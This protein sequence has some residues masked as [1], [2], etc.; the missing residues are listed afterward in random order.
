[1]MKGAGGPP[2]P[3]ISIPLLNSGGTDDEG[4]SPSVCTKPPNKTGLTAGG[5]GGAGDVAEETSSL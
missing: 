5:G 4:P 2:G 1:M 3:V